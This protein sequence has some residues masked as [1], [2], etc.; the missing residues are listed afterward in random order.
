MQ[1]WKSVQ[2]IKGLRVAGMGDNLQD[3]ARRAIVSDIEAGTYEPGER[4]P[5]EKELAAQLGVSLAPVRGALDQLA[6]RGTVVRRQGSG[7]Y[8]SERGVRY[9]L[10]SW[11]SCTDDLKNQGIEF[12]T[13]VLVCDTDVPPSEVADALHL[14]QGESA[15]HLVRLVYLRNEPGILLDSWTRDI[16]PSAFGDGAFFE[17]GR[18]LYGELADQGMPIMSADTSIEICF[19]DELESS[20]FDLPYASPLLQVTGV[21]NSRLG[22]TEWSR[23]RY[24][25]PI[26][27]LN[28]HREFEPRQM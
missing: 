2:Q 1:T 11:Q 25:A 15:F 10:E 16:D 21:A 28:M 8:V 12:D 27:S 23:L 18:S 6:Q 17:N 19:T 7:T 9:R 22:P 3:R 13:Q 5:A 20:L 4:L 24:N 26:F 14:Q